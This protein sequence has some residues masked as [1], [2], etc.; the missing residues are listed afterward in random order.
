MNAGYQKTIY[1]CFTGYIVQ[2]IINNFIPLLFLTF[3]SSY[4]IPLSQI[5]MLITFNFG[6][7]LLVDLLS[8]GFVDKI[9]YRAAI[10]LAHIFAAAGLLGL[11][12]LP[13][14]LP[15]AYAGLLIS[16]TVYA[17]GGG[18]LE[19]LVSPIV[20]SC[21]TDNKE[22]AMSLL[23]SFYCWGHVGVVLFSTL[24]FRV[25]G[26]ENW[27][28]LTCIWLIVPVAN[29][30][31]FA[32]TP[33][34]PLVEE[35]EKGMSMLDLCKTRVFWVLM[36]M[37]LCAGA[38]EQAVS[39]W[40]STFAERGLGVSKTLG[41]L[42]GPM[43]FA[44]L[45]GS[46]RAFYGKF[47]DKI[48]LDKFMV[49]SGLLCV[50]SYLCIS[51]S[52][53][54]VLSLVGCGICGLSVGIMWPG[55]FSKASATLRNGGTALFALLALAGDLGCSGGPTLVGYVSSIASDDLKKGIL[56][57]IIFPVLLVAGIFLLKK[58]GEDARTV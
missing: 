5:T 39:Q 2:A 35:G 21:P 27:K 15:S 46:A 55:S 8:T 37:M 9:G 29:T 36:L 14:V 56:T 13:E 17:L 49:G 54:P 20:E 44:V 52:P 48:E 1:A 31:V 7:Q 33:I 6:I 51:L 47:G 50:L 10:M 18:L 43:A 58:P 42:A 40:A 30:F 34:A 12:V 22:K 11:A 28:I 32:K 41:D 4:N 16:V 45:M 23:H 26:I 3:E 25:F 57:A 24:F 19:V 38:S 53:S